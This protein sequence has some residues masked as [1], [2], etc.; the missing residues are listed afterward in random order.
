MFILTTIGRVPGG[1]VASI[2]PVV[3]TIRQF[4]TVIISTGTAQG[5]QH[6]QVVIRMRMIRPST[7]EAVKH[8]QISCDAVPVSI[9]RKKGTNVLHSQTVIVSDVTVSRSRGLWRTL[10]QEV[11]VTSEGQFEIQGTLT[12]GLIFQWG[13]KIKITDYTLVSPDGEG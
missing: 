9:I 5:L 12:E 6:K 11:H 2:G 10:L 4:V 13:Q 1:E 8:L 3:P 7:V